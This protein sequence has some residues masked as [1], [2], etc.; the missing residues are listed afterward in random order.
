MKPIDAVVLTGS[1]VR[2]EPLDTSHVP[3]LIVAAEEDRSAYDWTIVP[4]ADEVAAYVAAQLTRDGM[5]AFAQIRVS[6]DAPVGCTAFWNA[7][8]WPGREDVA[9]VMIGWTW[10]AASA[11]RTGINGEAKLLLLRHAFEE[12][13]A[14]R[15]ELMTDARNQ[16]SWRAI[17]RLGA[18]FE[19]VLRNWSPSNAP[20][21]EGR[22][23][24]SAMFSVTAAEWPAVKAALSARVANG[25]TVP[26]ADGQ[27]SALSSSRTSSS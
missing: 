2:L 23:R 11:Q 9:A 1:L 7:R 17:E 6:D 13:G 20:G 12:L 24:D 3:G 19:G 18:R 26:S 15:V 16:R 27:A 5:T 22:L 10:L 4:R 25:G 8:S 14:A 21:E